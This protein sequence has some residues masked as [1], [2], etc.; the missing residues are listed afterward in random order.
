MASV[1]NYLKKE[2]E[3]RKISL[4]ELSQRTKIGMK[5]L[6]AIE[7]DDYTIFPGETYII[8]FIRNYA[9][10]LTLNQLEVVNMY[11][12]MKIGAT[13]PEEEVL[14]YRNIIN[15]LPMKNEI[16]ETKKKESSAN[17]KRS[18]KHTIRKE[19]TK[20]NIEVIEIDEDE[21]LQEETGKS[22]IKIPQKKLSIFQ[23][24]LKGKK[25]I[26][27]EHII[28]GAGI[29]VIIIGIIFFFSFL[30]DLINKDQKDKIYS[31]LSDIKTLEFEG[32]ILQSDFVPNEYYQIKL[33]NKE[34]NILFEK[35]SE[36]DD[37]NVDQMEKTIEFTF[38][39]NGTTIPLKLKEEKSFDFNFDKEQDLIVCINSFHD[40]LINGKI[41]KLH[42]FIEVETNKIANNLQFSNAVNTNKK[43]TRSTK[44][45]N[46]PAGKHKIIF[47]AVV[48]EKTYI[49]AF[50]DGKE[51]EGI[52]YY[53]KDKVQLE[54]NEVLQLKIGNAGGIKAEINGTAT[55][56][57]KRGEIA[58]KTIK[59]ERDPYDESTYNLVI[60]DWQ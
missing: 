60:K 38:Q 29:V 57:G 8:G 37:A 44:P 23:N 35:M 27:L 56:L 59:W 54:A 7:V 33:G 5:Y 16:F 47:N 2:R 43:N 10:A 13:I 48:K 46:I 24:P 20:D 11:K 28:I 51:Q 40:D 49:K 42:N 41:K 52:I 15:P 36:V 3:K 30:W 9:R 50:I 6:K 25:L 12:G 34:Y 14:P 26:K 31:E 1:G 18:I 21:I 17:A 45:D 55:K 32:E 53:P 39:I 4:D 19:R 22:G 58:N